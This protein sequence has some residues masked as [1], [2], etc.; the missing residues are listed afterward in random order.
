MQNLENPFGTLRLF[1]STHILTPPPNVIAPVTSKI[2]A[3]MIACP[4]DRAPLPIEVPKL[5]CT[6]HLEATIKSYCL[7]K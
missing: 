4:M 5:D 1:V 2:L 6:L 7:Y 3:I